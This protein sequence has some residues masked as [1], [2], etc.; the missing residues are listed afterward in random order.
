MLT[1]KD[2]TLRI[3]A[4]VYGLVKDE[5]EDRYIVVYRYSN[6]AYFNALD[7]G[8][9]NSQF[10]DPKTDSPINIRE[11]WLESNKIDVIFTNQISDVGSDKK[12]IL[13]KAN[14][15][16]FGQ[17]QTDY[18]KAMD[19]MK[20]IAAHWS[21]ILEYEVTWDQAVKCM[22]AVKLA[23]LKVTPSH[24]DSWIDIAGYVGVYG[25]CLTGD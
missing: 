17:R 1:F 23:R 13:L 19:N 6:E 15:L 24:E 2:K 3:Y 7:E 16:I 8:L 4:I 25:K 14:E 12:S 9:F 5:N 21:L 11:I 18:G 22:I 10:V 20:N